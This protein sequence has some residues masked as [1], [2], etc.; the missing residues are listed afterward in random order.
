MRRPV[1]VAVI[2]AAAGED[3][4]LAQGSLDREILGVGSLDAAA[5]SDLAFCSDDGA[6]GAQAAAR[7]RAG[8]IIARP[9]V[10]EDVMAAG[11]DAAL[12]SSRRPRLAFIRVVRR[13]FVETPS[14]GIHPSAIIDAQCRLGQDVH[15][16]PH[17]YVGASEVG[18][19]TSIHGN[20]H[21]YPGTRIGRDVV[22]QAGAVIGADGFGFERDA[23]GRLLRFPHL[24]NVVIEDEV[25]VGANACIDRGALGS[26]IIGRGT[27][28]DDGV[29]IAHNVEIG[30]DCMIIG[31]AAVCGSAR[32]GARSWI[33]PGATVR[34][35]TTV[36]AEA[37]VGLGATVVSDVEAGATVLGTPARASSRGISTGN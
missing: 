2:L 15:V 9:R 11:A 7:S 30:A 3:A 13:H 16:G 33:A 12:V 28:I 31:G 37:V 25:E 10:I 6:A 22:I 32:I 14:Q 35:R 19:R 21:V 26:T 5:P 27:K 18:D 24:G 36:G 34:E 8:V 29:Y 17:T 1:T 23:D 4:A 20:V